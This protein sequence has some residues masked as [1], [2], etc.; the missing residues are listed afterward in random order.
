VRRVLDEAFGR[1]PSVRA[2]LD[3][4]FGETVA[5]NLTT[6]SKSTG[7]QLAST[8]N[9]FVQR[10][11]TFPV[12][13]E[14]WDASKK[15]S[16]EVKAT[17]DVAEGAWR[18]V[19]GSSWNRR[20]LQPRIQRALHDA[21]PVPVSWF[22]DSNALASSGPVQGSSSKTT[23]DAKGPGR[24]GGHLTVMAD[25]QVK[26]PNGEVRKA[27]VT[28]EPVA[29]EAK[30]DAALQTSATLEF[31]RIENSWG[32]S[33]LDRGFV[34]GMGGYHELCMDQRNGPLQSCDETEDAK[35]L[36]ERGCTRTAAGLRA[37]V[38]PPWY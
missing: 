3:A 37:V 31:I 6:R 2:Q 5:R 20:D 1:S 25:Y 27:G 7:K 19:N 13:Y 8:T 11:S 35:P 38:M 29:D 33:R 17:L 22:V 30:L 21:Q 36:A 15:P 28:L 16:V 24:Q 34:P 12:A 9:T 4:V 23:L 18:E 26:L 32:S 10:T 14:Q